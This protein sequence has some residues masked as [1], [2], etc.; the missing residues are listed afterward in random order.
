[1]TYRKGYFKALLDVVNFLEKI[2]KNLI[3][4]PKEKFV[5]S[6]AALKAVLID[7]K[8]DLFMNYGGDIGFKYKY[9]KGKVLNI[10]IIEKKF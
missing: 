4:P 7:N 2:E 10:E 9:E 5:V 6:I 8:L 3:A 1:M